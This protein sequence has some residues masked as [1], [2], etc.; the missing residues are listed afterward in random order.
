MVKA[1]EMEKTLGKFECINHSHKYLILSVLKGAIEY[2]KLSIDRVELRR[3]EI[4][5]EGLDPDQMIVSSKNYIESIEKTKKL[6]QGVPL[7][8]KE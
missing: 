4:I 2:Q 5:K 3:K 1:R 7:C 6:F 8:I